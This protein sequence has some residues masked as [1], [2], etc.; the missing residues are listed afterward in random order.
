ME[1]DEEQFSSDESHNADDEPNE[2]YIE[3][4]MNERIRQF[5]LTERWTN[6]TWE[7]YRRECRFRWYSRLWRAIERSHRPIQNRPHIIPFEDQDYSDVRFAAYTETSHEQVRLLDVTIQRHRV[8][9]GI[10]E[11]EVYRVVQSGCNRLPEYER[12]FDLVPSEQLLR[13][14]DRRG[15]PQDRHEGR[16][17]FTRFAGMH[18]GWY[19]MNQLCFTCP[20]VVMTYFLRERPTEDDQETNWRLWTICYDMIRHEE[21]FPP[22]ERNWRLF[23][24]RSLSSTEDEDNDDSDETLL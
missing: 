5:Y 20:D 17:T 11:L 12:G 1:E 4:D 6:H 22:R 8:I 2:E 18:I 19:T 16:R 24:Y 13:R 21:A 14:M 9:G 15:F 3:L 23:D 7:L 10:L